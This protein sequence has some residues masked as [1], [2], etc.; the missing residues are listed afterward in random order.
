VLTLELDPKKVGKHIYIKVQCLVASLNDFCFVFLF[1]WK[2]V[3]IV[4]MMLFCF[5]EIKI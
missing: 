3:M 2:I 1:R 4:T 5:D